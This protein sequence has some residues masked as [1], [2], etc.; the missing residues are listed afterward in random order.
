MTPP[1]RRQ[2]R[3]QNGTK[4]SRK[5]RSG[6]LTPENRPLLRPSLTSKSVTCASSRPSHQS[7]FVSYHLTPQLVKPYSSDRSSITNEIKLLRPRRSFFRH[8][9]FFIFHSSLFRVGL[10]F[11]PN[12]TLN[13][14]S[15][16]RFLYFSNSPRFRYISFRCLYRSPLIR[17]FS[18]GCFTQ[19]STCWMEVLLADRR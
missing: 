6:I 14:Y 1:L 11:Q 18:A 8:F 17:V 5:L 7:L 16:S 10:G 15:H 13:R 3:K 4:K 9:S 2:I 19:S 12:P